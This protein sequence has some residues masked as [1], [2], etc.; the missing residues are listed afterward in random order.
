MTVE[1]KER[2]ALTDDRRVVYVRNQST[3]DGLVHVD[4]QN[5]GRITAGDL[6]PDGPYIILASDE[7]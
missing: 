3:V 1:L 7:A 2:L 4:L 6:G 5:L